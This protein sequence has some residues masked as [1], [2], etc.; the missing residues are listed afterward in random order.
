MLIFYD[1]EQR[2]PIMCVANQRALRPSFLLLAARKAVF[3]SFFKATKS[4]V[5]QVIHIFPCFPF[6]QVFRLVFADD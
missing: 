4:V 6:D 3:G 2:R 1:R 5:G